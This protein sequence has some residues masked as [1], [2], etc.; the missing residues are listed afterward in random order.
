MFLSLSLSPSF[1]YDFLAT[2]GEVLPEVSRKYLQYVETWSKR[3]LAGVA[4]WIEL[5]P[6]NQRVAGLVPSQGAC[7]G[8]GPGQVPSGEYVRDSHTLMF[9]SFSFFLPFPLK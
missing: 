9:L 8:G 7:L 6:A 5:R 3:A 2:R 1:Y 4:Q